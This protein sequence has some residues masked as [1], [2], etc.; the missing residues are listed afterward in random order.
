M[1]ER[2]SRTV[3][4]P[5][6]GSPN[7]SPGP[8]ATRRLGAVDAM[9]LGVDRPNNLMVITSVVLLESAPD[10]DA[11]ERLIRDRVVGR[12][13]VFRQR[14]VSSPIAVGR[15][16]W[17]D[18]DDF[19][20]GRHVHRVSLPGGGDAR[21]QAFIGER[22]CVPFDRSHP[23]WE[24]YLVDGYGT[25]AALVCRSHHSLADGLALTRVLL[26][27]T[28]D[29]EGHAPGDRP[30]VDSALATDEVLEDDAGPSGS[31]L[32]SGWPAWP[33]SVV[34]D[35]IG[36]AVRL[37][38][39]G[40]RAAREVTSPG[41]IPRA[42]DLAWRTIQ[43]AGSLLLTTNPSTPL[44]G[45][46]TPAKLVVWSRPRSLTGLK[47]LGRLSDA[48]I[49]DV[50]MSAAAASVHAY[51]AEHGAPP[52]DLTTMVPVNLRPLDRP[53]PRTLGNEFALVLLTLP[54][55][56]DSP[57]ARLA[58]TKR[59]MD[60]I[61]QSP[62]PML[63]YAIINVVGLMGRDLGRYLVDFFADKA[64]GVTTN[65]RGPDR[66]RFLAGTAVTGVLGWVPGSGRQ[67]LGICIFTYC[68][69]VQVG[70]MS[71]AAVIPDPGRLLAAFEAELDL[72]V[73][74]GHSAKRSGARRAH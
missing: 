38:R 28:D 70:F 15:P 35:G 42:A 2:A 24:V 30:L 69:H 12:Y 61:K 21:L 45:E 22:A 41:G 33:A 56:V 31:A 23:L 51:Q 55:A 11:V 64:I 18:D 52:A 57:L 16:S 46:P 39:L 6:S 72:L 36:A 43:V 9:W 73:R 44:A 17:R 67:T 26:S 1:A 20:L 32:G 8:A 63:T 60:W 49:N 5:A 59:R 34:S 27:L 3:T 54:S 4:E 37:G 40:W 48:T 68:G 58:E 62:E 74:V 7:Q 65:V 10:W 66:R 71:D 53:L 14:P 25:G 47:A 19:D 29:G 13:P 50:L